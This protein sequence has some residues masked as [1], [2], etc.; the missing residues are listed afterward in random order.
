MTTIAEAT[1][2]LPER[3]TLALGAVSFDGKDLTYN[4]PSEEHFDAAAAHAVGHGGFPMEKAED[5]APEAL[6]APDKAL[7]MYDLVLLRCRKAAPTP[8]AVASFKVEKSAR[9]RAVAKGEGDESRVIY[10]VVT[11]VEDK[12]AHANA[13]TAEEIAEGCWDF[14]KRFRVKLE[15]GRPEA[16]KAWQAA[17]VCDEQGYLLGAEIVENFRAYSHIKVGDAFHEGKS[18]QDIP[19][20]SHLA[21]MR[22]PAPVWPEFRDTDHGVSWGGY[23]AEVDA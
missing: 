9:L 6:A 12:D 7:A 20:G 2:K 11:A 10:Y 8:G 1:A 13:M 5:V 22:Y 23:A 21:A 4:L 3:V 15:H 18:N 16:M 19:A 17:G 14:P